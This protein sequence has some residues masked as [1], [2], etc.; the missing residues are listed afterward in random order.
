MKK[1]VLVSVGIGLLVWL[2]VDQRHYLFYQA[3]RLSGGSP[4]A[5]IDAVDELPSTVWFDDYYTVDEIG[6]GTFA[7]GETRYWQQNFNYLVVGEHT[8]L[9]FDAG[10][11]VRDIR[12]VVE[13][14]TDLPVIFLPSHFHYDHVGNGTNFAQRAVVDLPYLRARADGDELAFTKMEHLG[15]IEG[16]PIPT[17][18][19]DHWWAPDQ[20]IDLGGRSVAVIHTPGHS[21][22]SISLFDESNNVILSG[23]FLYEGMLYVFVPGSSVQDYLTTTQTLLQKYATTDV[24]YGAHRLTPPGPPRLARQDV[25]ELEQTLLNIKAG[26]LT[27]SGLYP[28]T[29]YVNQNISILAD[30]NFLHDWK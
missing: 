6:T 19:V 10:P 1:I 16:F 25:A 5:L 11:G 4:P 24:Y 8:A 15:P 30:P 2:T 22:E 17:W 13:S 29:Y 3:A 23:D 20:P 21:K 28:K 18:T 14:I 26:E 9:L 7:I 27:G 12:P